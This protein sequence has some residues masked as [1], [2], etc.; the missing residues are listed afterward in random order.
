MT[1]PTQSDPQ[2]K[3]R[4]PLDLKERIERAAAD[5]NRSMNAEIVTALEEKFPPL[6]SG[7]L[8]T[9]EGRVLI[10]LAGRIRKRKPVPGSARDR[11][12]SA[13]ENWAA[14]AEADS[15]RDSTG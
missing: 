1:I 5:N 14:R 9:L 4:L 15:G 13:Y 7:R 11:R 10:W 3:L 2:F 8:K 12:A 6:P